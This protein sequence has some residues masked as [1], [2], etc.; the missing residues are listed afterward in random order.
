MNW[1]PRWW[2]DWIV[3]PNLVLSN[4]LDDSTGEG[5]SCSWAINFGRGGFPLGVDERFRKD[6]VGSNR[7]GSIFSTR[8]GHGKIHQELPLT[9]RD[10]M[11]LELIP[12]ASMGWWRYPKDSTIPKWSL[13]GNR[14]GN[15]QVV[16]PCMDQKR[17]AIPLNQPDLSD[18]VW[19]K[20][21]RLLKLYVLRGRRERR[22]GGPAKIVWSFLLWTSQTC[23]WPIAFTGYPIQN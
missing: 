10:F 8:T 20:K 21:N 5:G 2:S 17:R 13:E 18:E 4:P 14:K 7:W 9:V 12:D 6:W 19:P 11:D 3:T 1:V 23:L 22:C 16:V 15:G